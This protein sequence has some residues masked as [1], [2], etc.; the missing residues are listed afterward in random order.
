MKNRKAFITGISSTSLK[1]NEVDFLKKNKPWGVILFSRNIN[2]FDQTKILINQIKSCFKDS[3]YPILI[4]EEGG[5]VSRLTKIIDTSLFSQKLFG[6]MY[7]KDNKRFNL[8]FA[9]YVKQLSYVL[10]LC[11]ININTVP[12]LDVIRKFSSKVLKDRCYSS[13]PKIVLVRFLILEVI[14]K[15]PLVKLLKQFQ[16]SWNMKLS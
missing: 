3:R 16:K 11:G 8:Y 13:N 1:A 12:V 14:L 7:I 9:T 2:N 15:Y 5:K 10:T 4:D 6:E